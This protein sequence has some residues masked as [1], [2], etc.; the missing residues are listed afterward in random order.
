MY[1]DIL[2]QIGLTEGEI[3]VYEFLLK[4][5][6]IPAG[7]VIKNTTLKRGNAYNI[8]YSLEKR[9]LVERVDRGKK[10]LF[11]VSHPSSLIDFIN[12]ESRQLEDAQLKLGAV[13]P[14]IV[15]EYNLVLNKPGI[16]FYEGEEGIKK[17]LADTL[18][19]K[20][21]IYTYADIEAVIKYTEQI[22]K[23]YIK[24]RDKLQINKKVITIDSPFARNFFKNYH[25]DITD[26]RFIDHEAYPFSSVMQIYDNHVAYISLSKDAYVAMLISDK[27]IYHMQKSLFKYNWKYAKTYD[28]L[29]PLSKAQ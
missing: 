14:E 6:E 20:D 24:K 1:Q 2:K 8:L 28:A 12:Q 9:G 25:K 23:E 17:V 5:G 7:E 29:P 13:L 10:A 27:N 4:K 11:R 15:S 21:V 16:K 18:T 19:A 26:T 22:N 3:T